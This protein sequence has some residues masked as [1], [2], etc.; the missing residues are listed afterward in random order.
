MR[1]IRDRQIYLMLRL[2]FH[3]GGVCMYTELNTFK[4]FNKRRGRLHDK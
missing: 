2:I 1:V 3:H 4:A